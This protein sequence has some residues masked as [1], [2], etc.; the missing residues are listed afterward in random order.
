MSGVWCPVHGEKDAVFHSPHKDYVKEPGCTCTAL[1]Y[2]GPYGESQEP[3][4]VTVNLS[5]KEVA[6]NYVNG[7]DS[8]TDSVLEALLRSVAM[9]AWETGHE[10]CMH[11]GN[12]P[13]Y[14]CKNPYVKKTVN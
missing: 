9:R 4:A 5:F 6:T 14:S 11:C 7:S 10:A 8:G 12:H 2:V 3:P 13:V 1:P